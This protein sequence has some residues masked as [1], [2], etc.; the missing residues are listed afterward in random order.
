[1]I[2]KQDRRSI[3]NIKR[4]A[5]YINLNRDKVVNRYTKKIKV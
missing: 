1:M 3:K 5:A 2:K 4:L